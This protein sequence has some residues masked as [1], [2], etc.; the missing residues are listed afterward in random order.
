MNK[1]K[2]T[3]GVFDAVKILFQ[4]NGNA[5]EIARFMKLS[6]DVVY[7]IR[8]AETLEEYRAL[9]YA[10]CE[11]R[12]KNKQVAAIKAK[13]SETKAEP[14]KVVETKTVQVQA[15]HYMCEEQRKTNEL[16]TLINQKLAFIV[17]ELTGVKQDA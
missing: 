16:L 12:K 3:Q 5:A 14:Q 9:M 15:S 2:V 13:E 11:K 7:M 4:S 10:K 8:D 6:N 17:F 1:P